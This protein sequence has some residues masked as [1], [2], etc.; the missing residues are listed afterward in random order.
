[1]NVEL[2][3]IARGTIKYV[4]SSEDGL[5]KI[6]VTASSKTGVVYG[7]EYDEYSMAGSTFKI[8]A[9]P[10]NEDDGTL[11]QARLVLGF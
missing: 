1:M 5:V 10:R 6:F 8:F 11:Q 3:W 4:L 7:F 9:L 2:V